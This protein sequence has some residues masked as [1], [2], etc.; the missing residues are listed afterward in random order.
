MKIVLVGRLAAEE[1]SRIASF[2]QRYQFLWYVNAG[3][4]FKSLFYFRNPQS[5]S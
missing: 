5:Q 1:R 4:F 3:F 2:V